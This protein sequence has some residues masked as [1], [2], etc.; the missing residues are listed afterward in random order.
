MNIGVVNYQ[1]SLT[2]GQELLA[3]RMVRELIKQGHKAFLITGPFHDNEPTV[4][5][6]ALERSVGGYLLSEWSEFQIPIIRVDGHLSSWPPRRIMFNDFLSILRNIADRFRLD[7]IISHSTLWNGPEEIAK[8]VAWKKML[9]TQGL[10][11]REV[12]YVHMP[13]YQPPDPIQYNIVEKAYRTAWN[14][15]IF[16]HLFKAAKTILCTTPIE[17][18]Q[19]LSMGARYEQCQLYPGGIDEEPFQKYRLNRA[20]DFFDVHSIPA[21]AK[22]VTYLGTIEQRKNPLAVVKVAKLLRRLKDVHFVIAGRPS[23]Q[24][25]AVR[26]MASRMRNLSYVGTVS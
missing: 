13:H 2:K 10:D 24:D 7:V 4:E 9:K 6:G 25:G 11:G 23:N 8:F 20:S 26:K 19:M 16:P 12:E 15:L 3:Q 22:I 17:R 5:Y 21:D 1:T 18:D 14:T